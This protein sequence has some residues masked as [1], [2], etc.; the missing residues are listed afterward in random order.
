M[1]LFPSK[2]QV[3]LY[4]DTETISVVN[5]RVAGSAISVAGFAELRVPTTLDGGSAELK[6]K[7]LENIKTVL[8]SAGVKSKDVSVSVPGDGSMTRHFELPVLPKKEERGA[9]R[10]EAQKY[11]PFDMKD[12]YYDYEVY[13]DEERKRNRIVFFACKKQW[14]DSLSTLLTLAGIRIT[15]VELVS[16]SVARAFRQHAVKTPDEVSLLIIAN[17]AHTAELVI[18][19]NGSVLT[20]RHVPLARAADNASL[21]VPVFVSDVRISLDYFSENFRNFKVQRVFVAT[22]FPGETGTLC[23][24]LKKDLSLSAEAGSLFDPPGSFTSTTAATAA[25]GLTLAT[26]EKK[27]GRRVS[28]KPTDAVSAGPT[29]TWEQEKK[30]LQ[31]LAT[32]G[33]IGVVVLLGALFFLFS[34]INGAK[35]RELAKKIASYPKARD[36][37]ISLPLK[38]LQE[39]QAAATQKVAFFSAL[40][41]GR[42][43]LTPKMNELVKTVPSNIRLTSWSYK[44][45]LATNGASEIDMTMEG[46]VL[47]TGADTNDLSVV[48]KFVSQLSENKD[49]MRGLS[50]IRI[51]ATKKVSVRSQPATQ[52]TLIFTKKKG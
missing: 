36:A 8:S 23:E 41:D 19:R 12:V 2:S 6:Q 24:A 35:S 51:G 1:A 27:K 18:Q 47:S 46:L 11:V 4:V 13:F 44:D 43:Y 31:D 3:G 49:F 22:P 7:T 17:D 45:E 32:K 5:G 10:F 9:V 50:E 30:Q 37:K 28:L 33:L 34:S 39:K 15:Q 20:T 21:D 29:L 25:Y 52:F 38:T 42:T 14:V 40:V 26:L 16:Q 48:N